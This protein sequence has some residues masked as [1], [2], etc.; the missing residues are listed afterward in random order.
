MHPAG[1][2]LC[3]HWV[4]S[5]AFISVITKLPRL[6][7][8]KIPNYQNTKM[9]GSSPGHL[10]MHPVGYVPPRTLALLACVY[11]GIYQFTSFGNYQNTKLPKYQNVECFTGASADASSGGCSP[12]TRWLCPPAYFGIYQFTNFGNYQNTKFGIYQITKIPKLVYREKRN[13]GVCLTPLPPI[14]R[15]GQSTILR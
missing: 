11:F 13:R 4:H 2:I 9:W 8:T 14:S 7:F 1:Y 12:S 15:S 6:V 5:L 3:T 10:L